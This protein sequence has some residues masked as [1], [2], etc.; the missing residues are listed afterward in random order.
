M[1]GACCG[2]LQQRVVL[3]AGPTACLHVQHRLQNP[4]S[5]LQARLRAL[6]AL[7]TLCLFAGLSVRALKAL[8]DIMAAEQEG[9]QHRTISVRCAARRAGKV[10]RR[11]QRQ[12]QRQQQRQRQQATPQACNPASQAQH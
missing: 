9:G 2:T 5:S 11:M 10:S 7:V 12:Q 4:L 3:V 1:L 6:K 8:F